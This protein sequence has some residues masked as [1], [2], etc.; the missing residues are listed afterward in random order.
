MIKGVSETSQKDTKEQKGRSLGMLLGILAA[1]LLGNLL[2]DK[3][4]APGRG[5]IRTGDGVI[6]AGQ[7]VI[8]AGQNF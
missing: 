1:S 3:P 5:V 4:K 6:Q 8:R 7:G 2:A